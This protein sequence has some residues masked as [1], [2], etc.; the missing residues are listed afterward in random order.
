MNAALDETA[1]YTMN[2]TQTIIVPVQI[3]GKEFA[4]VTAEYTQDALKD[5]EELDKRL[6]G[7]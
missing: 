6:R 5:K 3:D 7:E 4:R 1:E 2:S